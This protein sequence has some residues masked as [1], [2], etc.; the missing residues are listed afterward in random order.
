MTS[1]QEDITIFT[2]LLISTA[3]AIFFMGGGWIG[4]A[5]LAA[6]LVLIAGFAG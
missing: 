1:D 6:A 2:A 5:V 3:S 4:L